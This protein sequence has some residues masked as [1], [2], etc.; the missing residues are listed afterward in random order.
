M[1]ENEY[2]LSSLPKLKEVVE[3]C[4]KSIFWR[5]RIHIREICT[6]NDFRNIPI[7]NRSELANLYD[8]G[9]VEELLT[10]RPT[11]SFVKVS[12]GGKPF[13]SPLISY[14]SPDEFLIMQKPISKLFRE[15]KLHEE[16]ILITFPGT[17]PYPYDFGI[18]IESEPESGN[19]R[20]DHVSGKIFK[21]AAIQFGLTTYCTGLR[22]LAYK[23]SDKEALLEKD[24]L[25]KA[26]VITKPQ[27]LAT[28]PNVLREIF[29][30]ALEKGK[31]LFSNYETNIVI[32]GGAALTSKDRDR[33]AKLG[34]PWLVEWIESGELGTIAYSTPYRASESPPEWLKTT[35]EENFFELVDDSGVSIFLCE[36]GRIIATRLYTS[37]HPLIRYDIE[38]NGKFA[39]KG[40]ELL[41]YRQII[42]R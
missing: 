21:S 9:F 25:F 26:L 41:L 7:V 35:W 8:H 3:N 27:I 23:I 20:S 38:D 5:N 33:L 34:N 17:D 11:D 40:N 30:P 4:H 29:M 32:L 19:Y 24:R 28:S 1:T 22:F 15:L 16:K 31:E 6:I 18:Q 10:Q 42:K 2:I 13:R 12:T 14:L 37:V 36:W 39:F